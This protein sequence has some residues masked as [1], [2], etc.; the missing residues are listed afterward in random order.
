VDLS[1]GGSAGNRLIYRV[2]PELLE[3][4]VL[5]RDAAGSAP[6]TPPITTPT[7]T[8]APTTP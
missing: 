3:K 5:M 7:E 6:A 1:D 4:T 8:A 2:H